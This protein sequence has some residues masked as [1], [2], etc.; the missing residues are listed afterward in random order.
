MTNG[1]G[2]PLHGEAVSSDMG[3]TVI[4]V[5]FGLKARHIVM[6]FTFIAGLIGTGGVTGAL[7]WPAKQQDMTIVQQ[8]VAELRTE[9]KSMQEATTRLVVAVEGLQSSVDD[10][11]TSPPKAIIKAV[12]PSAASA[13]AKSTRGKPA[14]NS[15]PRLF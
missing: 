7:F 9:M 10:L 12:K 14:A 1:A 2:Q 3:P 5:N 6:A 11:R 13:R 15:T 4:S 8:A